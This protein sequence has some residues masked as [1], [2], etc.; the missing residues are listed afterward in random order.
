MQAFADGEIGAYQ[1]HRIGESPV[2]RVGQLVEH[3]VGDHQPMLGT[4]ADGN[5]QH[6]PILPTFGF[7]MQVAQVERA[8]AL[9]L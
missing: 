3:L 1:E 9:Q 7:G 6:I 8:D 5:A 4:E 2:L